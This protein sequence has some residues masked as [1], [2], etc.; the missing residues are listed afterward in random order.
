[1]AINKIVYGGNTLVDLTGDTVT[2][3]TLAEGVT[4]HD[5]SGAVITGIMRTSEDLNAVLVEQESLIAELRA[6]LRG[7]TEGEG[8]INPSGEI[9]ITENGTYDVTNYAFAEVNVSPE[10]PNIQPLNVTANGTYTPSGDVDGFGPVTVNVSGGDSD[11][12]A[13]LEAIIN[14]TATSVSSTATKIGDYAF[15]NCTRLVTAD[16]P[17]V[18]SIGQYAFKYCNALKNVHVPKATTL[19]A[20]SFEDSAIQTL[21][22]PSATSI[23][24]NSF[25]GS[26]LATLIIRTTSKVCTLAN[27][28]ALTDTP[29]EDG[30]GYIYVPESLLSAYASA[31]NWSTFSARLRAIENYPEITGG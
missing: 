31:S 3:E 26:K 5:K 27:K 24:A 8:G 15:R 17:N 14:R 18:T 21:D 19:A 7:K 25:N 10:E 23:A 6:T 29:I 12:E 2:P 1:M 4:A 9:K 13:A 30:T 28:N 20:Y 22:L 16:L 11:A